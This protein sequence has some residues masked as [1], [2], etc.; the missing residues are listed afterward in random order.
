MFT[1]FPLC[2]ITAILISLCV[3]FNASGQDVAKFEESCDRCPL[4]ALKSNLLHDAAITPDIG[5][6]LSISRRVSVGIEGVYAWWS[7]SKRNRCWRIRGGWLDVSYWP[8]KEPL[9]QRLTGHH[10]GVYAS[11]HDYDFEFGHKGWQ[12]RR[13]TVGAGLTYGYSFRING[14][15]SVDLHLRAGYSGGHITEYVPQCGKYFCTRNF[16]SNYFGIT[17]LGVTL[18]WFPGRGDT[19][20]P[21][22]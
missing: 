20:N 7:D 18:I 12:A 15:L 22:K 2:H 9:R 11:M 5:V 3:L 19:N 17:D 10:I 8:G 16:H 4:V 1:S 14:R 21:R 13:P 6:E